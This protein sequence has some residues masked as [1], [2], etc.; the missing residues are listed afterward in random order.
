[1]PAE[2]LTMVFKHSTLEERVALSVIEKNLS[3]LQVPLDGYHLF[4]ENI[5]LADVLLRLKDRKN[6]GFSI[7][8]HDLEFV[9]APVPNFELNLFMV[10]SH[11]G[12][13][14]DEW[15]ADLIGTLDFVMAWVADAE[16]EFWQNAENLSEYTTRGKSHEALPK[17]S[18][19]LPAPLERTIVDTT[20][21]PGR[22]VL[23]IGYIEA[24]GRTMWL[25]ERFWQLTGASKLDLKSAFWL[26]VSQPLPTIT[27]LQTVDETFVRADGP[28]GETQRELRSLLFPLT[29]LQIR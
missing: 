28:S 16:Y 24:V 13:S 26:R 25:G 2:K 11:T 10:G 9:F 15:A 22:R 29:N 1:M 27:K 21:N 20:D 12:T 23:R 4:G 6:R 18:N 8:G 19:G 7:T 14:W 17:K 5:H 3:R